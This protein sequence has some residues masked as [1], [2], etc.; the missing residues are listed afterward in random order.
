M[1]T[2]TRLPLIQGELLNADTELSLAELCRACRISADTLLELVDQGIIEPRGNNM[3]GW[4][5]SGNSVVQ[6][7][8]AIHLRRDLGVNWA[9]AGL[10]LEL[11]DE[12]ARLRRAM[13]QYPDE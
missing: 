12:I 8:C 1:I 5:F 13:A 6:V 2:Q 9:G 7:R 4:R 3:Q 10:A 11:L